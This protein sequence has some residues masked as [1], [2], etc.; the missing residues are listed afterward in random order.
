MKNK[1]AVVI[2]VIEEVRGEW[3]NYA[4]KLNAGG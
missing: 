1:E 3:I 4:I 2:N